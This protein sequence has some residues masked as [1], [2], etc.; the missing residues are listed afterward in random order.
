MVQYAANV[1]DNPELLLRYSQQRGEV[2]S[3]LL[4]GTPPG[5]NSF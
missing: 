2:C 4:I 3:R 5:A 1:L